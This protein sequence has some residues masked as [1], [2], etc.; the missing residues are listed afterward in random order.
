MAW[1]GGS[2]GGDPRVVPK[3]TN[4][5]VVTTS[6]DAALR[7]VKGGPHAL[8]YFEWG[9]SGATRALSGATASNPFPRGSRWL[10]T[11]GLGAGGF[12]RDIDIVKEELGVDFLRVDSASL[13]GTSPY[14]AVR[15]EGPGVDGA[16]VEQA[17]RALG[18]ETKIGAGGRQ[19]LARGE[20]GGYDLDV[21]VRALSISPGINRAVVGPTSLAI[22][23]YEEPVDQILGGGRTLADA[24]D[25][26][27]VSA[28]LGDAVG[29]TIFG[30]QYIS[31]PGVRLVAIG[32]RR[33][34]AGREAEIDEVACVVV[35]DVATAE[36]QA[37]TLRQAFESRQP[38]LSEERRPLDQ[39][40]TL[41]VDRLD[42][43]GV[44]MTRAVF[45]LKSDGHAGLLLTSYFNRDLEVYL[46]G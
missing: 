32:N 34:P 9:D 10:M 43:R 11:V 23:K 40:E 2:C 41:A 13:I 16:R 21:P 28:C 46:G 25:H 17:L 5:A 19:Y 15:L 18:A 12:L 20:E 14:V 36:K 38:G 42:H 33:P 8:D 24:P 29:A 1:L 3:K 39:V 30:K 26:A 4:P 44:V 7:S 37:A 31:L 27:A 22:G 6:L 35:D 45:R